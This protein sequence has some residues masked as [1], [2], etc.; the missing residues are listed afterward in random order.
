MY[1]HNY[2]ILYVLQEFHFRIKLEVPYNAYSVII[3][4]RAEDTIYLQGNWIFYVGV[5]NTPVILLE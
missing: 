4:I 2:Q 3:N 1:T 5:E